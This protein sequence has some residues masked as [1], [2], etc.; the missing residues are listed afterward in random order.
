M[1]PLCAAMML[2]VVSG[3]VNVEATRLDPR[4]SFAPLAAEDV[5]IYRGPQDIP[6]KY[7]QIALIEANSESDF[8]TEK[9]FF[10]SMRKK[11]AKMGANGIILEPSLEPSPLLRTAQVL[12]DAR[13][14]RYRHAVAILTQ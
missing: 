5:R 1:A 8:A 2:A 12:L 4:A 9:D 7:T 11:A 13:V 10:E 3:C 6:G 14:T